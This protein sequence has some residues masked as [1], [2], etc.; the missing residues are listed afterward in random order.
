MSLNSFITHIKTVGL[1]TGSNY[2]VILPK[3]S[4]ITSSPIDV[5]L[6]VE[7]VSIPGFNIMSTESKIFGEVSDI[8]YGINYPPVSMSFLIDNQYEARK[9]FED[10]MN[11]VFD[12]QTRTVG[13]Y[14]DYVQEIS[15]YSTDK[16]GK[17]IFA[18]TLHECWPKTLSDIETNNNNRE[19][20][21]CATSI[22]YKYWSRIDFDASGN[23]IQQI[24]GN[25]AAA[26][27]SG[28]GLLQLFN[29]NIYKETLA[30][31]NLS[32]YNQ[33]AALLS[34]IS[35]TG[36]ANYGP[37]AASD[38]IRYSKGAYSVLNTSGI[39]GPAGSNEPMFGQN[40]GDLIGILGSNMGT[41]GNAVG[42]I[43]T[44]ISS[45][46]G[47]VS[48]AGNA[49]GTTA[50]TIKSIDSLLNRVGIRTSLGSVSSQLAGLSGVISATAQLSGLPGSL[51]SVGA[52]MGAIGGA[53]YEVKNQIISFPG[54][55]SSS[56]NAIGRFADVFNSRGPELSNIANTLFE[57]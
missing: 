23:A 50:G 55:V 24:Y 37:N 29:S 52:N 32:P 41:F 21:R 17:P 9:Y 30:N 10:W 31:Y 44:S 15:I 4:K 7:S 19:P 26:P 20:I 33:S 1:P 47:P 5:A 46:S 39:S 34:G 42:N 8:P 16:S 2:Y 53:L 35:G 38:F 22:T 12:R 54:E 14:V 56:A 28:R 25:S 13:L 43:G 18:V 6:M 11:L 48:A 45:I 57:I 51:S 40:F 27:D 36:L 3:N 49:I